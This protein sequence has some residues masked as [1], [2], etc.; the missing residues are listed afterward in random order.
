MM[1]DNT[2]YRANR[3]FLV[4]RAAIQDASQYFNRKLLLNL[5]F[6]F[7]EKITIGKVKVTDFLNWLAG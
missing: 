3:Q 1:C 2:F 5:T 4:N 6:K 7:K